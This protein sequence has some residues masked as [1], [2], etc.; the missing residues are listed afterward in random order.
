MREKQF[1]SGEYFHVF[2]KS[3]AGYGIFKDPSNAE[4]YIHTLD[5]Y[6]SSIVSESFSKAIRRKVY[7][8]QN[9]VYLKENPLIKFISYCIMPD[10]YHLI[11]RMIKNHSLSKYINDVENSFTHFFNLKF[12][13]KG[14]LWQT[15][16]KAV[17]IISN[18]QLLHGT[19]Y[20]HLNPTS[21]G[22]VDKPENWEFSSYRDFITDEKILKTF[23]KDISIKSIGNYKKFVEDQK[24]YQRKLK[25]IRK[26]MFD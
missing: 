19:R 3:I 21:S 22:L 12:E 17:R 14:P 13:R 7:L 5:F 15:N 16:F 1:V 6:N 4:R 10:H 23:V 11:I 8:P 20:V 2:N 9:L 24:D 18:E 26:L 25:L